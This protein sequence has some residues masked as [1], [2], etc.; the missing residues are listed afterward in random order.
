MPKTEKVLRRYSNVLTFLGVLVSCLF[1]QSH[2]SAQCGTMVCNNVLQ[3]SMDENCQILFNP[4]LLLEGDPATQGSSFT[5]TIADLGIINQALDLT[6][7]IP[8]GTFEYKVTNQCG[9]SCWGKFFA[10]DNIGPRLVGDA[11][12]PKT[13][14]CRFACNEISTVLNDATFTTH[15]N[16]DFTEHCAGNLDV[17]FED[18]HIKATESC[19][20]DTI[21][22]EWVANV[23]KHGE[24]VRMVITTQ[25]FVFDP[26]DMDKVWMPPTGAITI[27]CHI[28]EHPDSIAA[29]L[30]DPLTCENE[31]IPFAYPHIEGTPMNCNECAPIEIHFKKLKELKED[32]P[33][34]IT[35]P[36][37]DEQ[38]VLIDQWTKETDSRNICGCDEWN[39]LVSEVNE[40]YSVEGQI[41]GITSAFPG[42]LDADGKCKSW[43]TQSEWMTGMDPWTGSGT[44]TGTGSG[45]TP[46]PNHIPLYGNDKVCNLITDKEDLIIPI[47]GTGDYVSSYKV[48]RTW[49]VYDWCSANT[50][51][52]VQII[53]IEDLEGPT[54][55]IQDSVSLSTDPWLCGVNYD[56]PPPSNLSDKCSP[57]HIS[58]TVHLDGSPSLQVIGD[59][60]D[61]YTILNIPKGD[62]KLIY[63][64]SDNCG[65]STQDTTLLWI[66]DNIPPV[67][68]AKE[69]IVVSLTSSGQNAGVAKV[70]YNS[71][72]NGSYDVCSPQVKIEIRREKDLCGILGND[73]YTS[74]RNRGDLNFGLHPDSTGLVDADGGQ[75]I[76]FCCDDLTEGTFGIHKVWMRVWDDAN[77]DGVIGNTGDN[78]NEVWAN[79]RVEDKLNVILTCP[80]DITVSCYVG[81]DSLS[82]L[83]TPDTRGA[84]AVNV[85][86]EDELP[87]THCPTGEVIRKWYVDKDIDGK[88]DTGEKFCKQIINVTDPRPMFCGDIVFPRDTIVDC[89]N[90]EMDTA[91]I[92]TG[93]HCGL[94]GF[95][96]KVEIFDLQD[97]YCY[98]I[99][100][101][102]TVI[103]WCQYNPNSGS[104]LGVC[105]GTQ[106][107]TV[108]DDVAPTFPVCEDKIVESA[109]ADCV[110]TDFTIS[111]TAIDEGDCPDKELVWSICLDLGSNRS[112]DYTYQA[113]TQSGEELVVDLV[114]EDGNALAMIAGTHSV[115][116]TVTDACD[117][118]A[119][120]TTK[121]IVADTKA[122]TPICIEALSTAVMST[123]GS[124]EIWATDFDPDKKSFDNCDK[125]LTYSFSG[126]EIISNL[127]I[128]CR[129]SG[130]D[131]N[132]GDCKQT[133][134]FPLA[135]LVA[136]EASEIVVGGQVLDLGYPFS[137]NDPFDQ[138]RLL[139]ELLALDYD[140]E[141]RIDPSD[142]S[143]EITVNYAGEEFESVNI[144]G[145]DSYEFTCTDCIGSIEN[146]LFIE[147]GQSQTFQLPMWVWDDG[148]DAD[149]NGRI[150]I[151]ERN[152]DWCMV[153]LRVDDNVGVCADTESSSAAMIAG[154]IQTD[155]G[156]MVEAVEVVISSMHPEHPS[157]AL[158]QNNG[159]YAFRDNPMQ[160]DYEISAAR[161]DDDINGVSTLDLVLIQKH[162]LG[163][164]ILDSPYKII[165]SDIN[166]D[167]NISARDLV[168]LRKLILGIY[169]ELPS[170]SSWRFVEKAQEFQDAYSPFP[171]IENI[172][173]YDLSADM[174]AQDFIGIKIGD[175]NSNVKANNLIASEV[176]ANSN[177]VL[178]VDQQSVKAGDRVE[179]DF[180][181]EDFQSV[182]GMQFTM[183]HTGLRLVDI[184]SGAIELSEDN[185]GIIKEDGLLSFSWGDVESVS[186]DEV[187]FTLTFEALESVELS[188]TINITSQVTSA[189]AY[190]S[191][192]YILNDVTLQFNYSDEEQDFVLYQN[193]PNPFSSKTEIGFSLPESS[194]VTLKIF[195]VNG[196]LVLQREG[197]YP[198]GLSI[199]ELNSDDLSSSGILYYQLDA[200]KYN[201]TKKMVMIN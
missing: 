37:G 36:S 90:A 22:R 135:T 138:Q 86:Y 45:T 168:E 59:A 153:M 180:R 95:S 82:V 78:Y 75:Y 187:L 133:V 120:C 102:F 185:I 24:E 163:L 196:K 142:Q 193:E 139:D 16:P 14:P 178:S 44:W 161:D 54:F 97:E 4:D 167:G 141:G 23:N 195:D 119:T 132:C 146:G 25:Y 13:D 81:L 114:D 130:D 1:F 183:R 109:D 160:L 64:V 11:T 110:V 173:I 52:S 55:T 177:M 67:A 192:S 175:V 169:A 80:K 99:V 18:K 83:G 103:D 41:I 48:V 7:T 149:C 53:K 79:V 127:M 28:S 164:T 199:I 107:I 165:A 115:T 151:D 157:M 94:F 63:T 38:W 69:N 194:S 56:V 32:V 189:E 92:W 190:T 181:S 66:K 108:S 35:D 46:S 5:L 88:F 60:D 121:L 126:E 140:V 50:K 176:R 15:L 166:N 158:T 162:I 113:V 101:R 8:I 6:E 150:S 136:V 197:S 85:V 89:A 174:L 21:K 155:Q 87:S 3:I 26:V 27:P 147:N 61:G 58:Y 73:T 137:L 96:E 51:K 62:Q 179:L 93:D 33:I 31:G 116:W 104:D 30:D 91:P 57:H 144:D 131:V 100:R 17:I 70:F 74:G 68:I 42:M 98:K 19:G 188:N 198:K 106:K 111:Q 200:G 154:D 128:S 10:E 201:A 170:N 123:N 191:D 65:N 159:L 152:K 145:G 184:A 134:V 20:I 84:C 171:F 71:I 117:N 124:V 9:N 182:Y 125:S 112:C 29:Y 156:V 12:C 39:Q 2:L 143:L 172:E 186:S 148:Y 129:P 118:D 43:P 77:M 122:P 40:T 76:K 72:N 49:T 105:Y 47:C 34:L